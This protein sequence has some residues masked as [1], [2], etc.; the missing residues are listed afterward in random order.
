MGNLC[1]HWKNGS[2]DS[3]KLGVAA[4][5]VSKRRIAK[6]GDATFK[7]VF[8]TR[9]WSLLLDLCPFPNAGQRHSRPLYLFL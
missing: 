9:L 8:I 2:S 4:Q 1:K 6:L 3:P 5:G 7:N